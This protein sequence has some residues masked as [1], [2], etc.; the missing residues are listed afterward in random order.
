M[1]LMIWTKTLASPGKHENS[2]LGIGKKQNTFLMTKKFYE[3][4][5]LSDFV[6]ICLCDMENSFKGFFPNA[7]LIEGDSWGNS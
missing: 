4:D 6:F 1:E 7:Y 2:T 5:L 3:R